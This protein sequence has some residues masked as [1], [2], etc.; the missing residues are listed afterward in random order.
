MFKKYICPHCYEKFKPSDATYSCRSC[1]NNF[2]LEKLP[3]YHKLYTQ[4]IDLKVVNFCP[5]N[6][7]ESLCK[8]LCPNCNK[9]FFYE[10]QGNNNAMIALIG[11]TNSGKSVFLTILMHELKNTLAQY[12]NYSLMNLGDTNNLINGLTESIYES[13]S[14]PGA[15]APKEAQSIAGEPLVFLFKNS[16]EYNKSLSLTF[17]D[18]AG[19]DLESGNITKESYRYI[20]H[21][22]AI[23]FLAD[24]TDENSRVKTIKT[25][26]TLVQT[27]KQGNAISNDNK[28][29]T[30]IVVLFTK[31]DMIKEEL[32]KSSNSFKNYEKWPSLE[33]LNSL[34]VEFE[35]FIGNTNQ[36][37]LNILRNEFVDYKVL[38]VSS[39]GFNPSN[40]ADIKGMEI[41]PYLIEY[42]LSY[43]IKKLLG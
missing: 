17:Y 42:S 26:E 43:F 1:K 37:I 21:S 33:T 34:S 5:V 3:L 9:E 25:L 2:T 36:N 15:T 27:V 32:E 11:G 14:L 23:I 24:I 18:A 10:L 8:T 12:G 31:A 35:S 39:L 22:K 29:S 13:H 19:E 6:K 7:H 41:K 30:P 4:F 28:I 16:A 20:V 38:P 40:G